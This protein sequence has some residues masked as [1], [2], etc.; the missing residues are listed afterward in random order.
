MIISLSLCFQFVVFFPFSLL[1]LFL[2]PVFPELSNLLPGLG[3]ILP[4]FEARVLALNRPYLEIKP[5]E[6]KNVFWF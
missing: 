2:P 1:F 6:K 4:N 5:K 3:N